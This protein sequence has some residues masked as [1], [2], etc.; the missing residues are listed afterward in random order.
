M[1]TGVIL[2][3]LGFH[4]PGSKTQALTHNP[5]GAV[6]NACGLPNSPLS[7]P[8]TMGVFNFNERHKL[9]TK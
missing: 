7:L 3:F 5:Q 2:P 4:F 6:A 9:V 8:W 1:Q